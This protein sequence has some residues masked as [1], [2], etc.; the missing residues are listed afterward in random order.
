MS[1]TSSPP[2]VASAGRTDRYPLDGLIAEGV[3]TGL[4]TFNIDLFRR[5]EAMGVPDGVFT[6]ATIR[7]FEP[8]TWWPKTEP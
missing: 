2:S 6:N 4:P 7:G 8:R 3:G 5:F 1:T